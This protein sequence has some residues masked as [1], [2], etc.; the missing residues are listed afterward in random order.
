[1][2]MHGNASLNLASDTE[3]CQLFRKHN[4]SSENQKPKGRINTNS[5]TL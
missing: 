5:E 4:A 1:M 2:S 3:L